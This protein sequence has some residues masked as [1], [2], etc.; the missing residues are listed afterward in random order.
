MQNTFKRES[1][2]TANIPILLLFSRSLNRQILIEAFEPIPINEGKTS[3]TIERNKLSEKNFEKGLTANNNNHDT[4]T[5]IS[6][7]TKTHK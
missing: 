5:L 4:N 6:I 7:P 3:H 1:Q 2:T